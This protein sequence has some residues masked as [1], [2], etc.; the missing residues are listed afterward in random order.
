MQAIGLG[1]A[2]NYMMQVGRE[3]IVR[4]EVVLKDYAH[5]RLLGPTGSS[6]AWHG[7]RT[8]GA[9]VAFGIDGLHP[10]DISTIIDRLR[11]GGTRRPPLRPTAD[12]AAGRDRHLSGLL[13]MYNTKAEVDALAEAL[14]KA[15]D[16]FA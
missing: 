1:A 16:F 8:R 11:G 15:H 12:A 2:L 13:A 14:I 5:E 6:S 7:C 9:I 10:H 4:H 3:R